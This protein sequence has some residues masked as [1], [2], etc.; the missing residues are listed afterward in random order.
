MSERK[1]QRKRVILQLKVPID[2][3]IGRRLGSKSLEKNL[4]I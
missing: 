1:S 2:K 4:C 3:T